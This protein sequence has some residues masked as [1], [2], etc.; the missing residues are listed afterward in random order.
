M[1]IRQ[2]GDCMPKASLET[3]ED[4]QM[5]KEYILLPVLNV[6]SRFVDQN[7]PCRMPL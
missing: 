7:Y 1:R 6:W 2:G 4:L 3:K 5:S